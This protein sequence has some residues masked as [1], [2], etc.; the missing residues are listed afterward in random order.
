MSSAGQ[1]S[2]GAIVWPQ[3]RDGARTPR[4]KVPLRL[5]SPVSQLPR[6]NTADVKSLR[7]LGL[8]T[9]RDLLLE[10]PYRWESFGGPVPIADLTLNTVATV[11]VRVVSARVKRTPRQGMLLTE[12][13]V[14]D[15]QG[16]RMKVVWFRQP[17]RA[18]RLRTGHRL[19]LAGVVRSSRYGGMEMQNPHTERVDEQGGPRWVGGLMPKYHLTGKLSPR[20]VAAWVD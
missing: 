20:K 5:D 6:I 10:L 1:P 4:P 16:P 13:V 17:Y 12:A 15:E 9:V 8:H 19:A 14:G 2:T 3:Q 18:A 7:K 11:L